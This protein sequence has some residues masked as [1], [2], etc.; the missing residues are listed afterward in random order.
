MNIFN[1]LK[2]QTLNKE[3]ANNFSMKTTMK[4]ELFPK[5]ILKSKV[6]S[7]VVPCFE[8]EKSNNYLSLLGAEFVDEYRRLIK[9]KEFTAKKNSL[10]KIS[11]MGKINTNYIFL[12]GLGN[13]A[14]LHN[15]T[16]RRAVAVA[17]KAIKKSKSLSYLSLLNQ[18][19]LPD[20]TFT[21]AE[22]AYLS[23]YSFD[24]YKTPI[25]NQN[26]I[27]NNN[28]KIKIMYLWNSQT[29]NSSK[30]NHQLN[31]AS[32]IASSTNYCRNLVNTPPN[33]L[34]PEVLAKEAR[35]LKSA[36][37]KVTVFDEKALKKL[38]CNAIL[39]VGM[40]SARK[41]R[42]IIVD[43]HPKGAKKSLAIVGKGITFD[44]GGLNIKP[45][46]YMET[47]K[48]DMSGAA[49]ALATVKA[50]K[51]LGLKQRVIAVLAAAENMPGGLSY[52]PDDIIK[53]FSGK[54]IEIGN[55]DAE[56]RVVLSDALAFTEKKIKPDQ[57]IDLATLTGACVVALGYYPSGMMTNDEIM[58]TSLHHAG[59]LSG[60]RVWRLPLWDDYQDLMKSDLA[61]VKNI[62]KG[63]DSGTIT[64]AIFLQ[65]FVE[66]TPWAHL[67]IA[68]TAFL[69]ESQYYKPKGGTGAGVR[70]L[71]EYLSSY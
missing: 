11:C 29:K 53:T 67:D 18:V 70:L 26:N 61:D 39:A 28:V 43:Y 48:C 21:V 34:Y 10:H 6:D 55:T 42:L 50:A 65:H 35:K 66:K 45:G 52:R 30:L 36:N 27:N 32:V 24:R 3:Q 54:T 44:S 58:A 57:I 71:V 8:D 41:P 17:H 19:D 33:E 40:G 49:C 38:G 16:L 1:L 2:Q 31:R 20:T 51:E 60:D 5:A 46:S 22:A 62:S 12:I 14:D 23:D 64:A 4:I 63:R 9:S 68:G 7:I 25:S 47:M 13:S 15:E 56:G 59:E 69:K 37:T